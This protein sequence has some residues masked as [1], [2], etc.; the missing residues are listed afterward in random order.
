MAGG[1]DATEPGHRQSVW[2]A[3]SSP[4]CAR[5]V[6]QLEFCVKVKND[7]MPRDSECIPGM[8]SVSRGSGV[9]DGKGKTGSQREELGGESQ[10]WFWEPSVPQPW[11]LSFDPLLESLEGL[12]G[13]SVGVSV[14]DQN[15]GWGFRMD[16]CM[17]EAGRGWVMDGGLPE[18]KETGSE[19]FYHCPENK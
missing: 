15:G 16:G 3:G 10:F 12:A 9:L 19:G 11:N 8:E 2:N 6:D 17:V 1:D 18:D 13:R 7:Q 5:G 4:A 14:L